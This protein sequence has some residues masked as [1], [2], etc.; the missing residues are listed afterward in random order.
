MYNCILLFFLEQDFNEFIND[1]FCHYYVMYMDGFDER[2]LLVNITFI[3]IMIIERHMT[4]A[5]HVYVRVPK[6]ICV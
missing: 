4:S 6:K 5:D 2:K 1:S 3:P